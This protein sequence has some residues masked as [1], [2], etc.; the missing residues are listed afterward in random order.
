M[1]HRMVALLAFF[2]LLMTATTAASYI[3]QPA[4]A[5]TPSTGPGSVGQSGADVGGVD[6]HLFCNTGVMTPICR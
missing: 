3:V 6:R 4:K 1:I 5:Q 2:G